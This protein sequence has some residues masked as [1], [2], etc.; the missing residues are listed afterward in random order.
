ME[1]MSYNAEIPTRYFGDSSQMEN[2]ISYS[3]M[4]CHMTTQIPGFYTGL[5]GGNG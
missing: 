5:I 4:N 2:W 3:G 1:R